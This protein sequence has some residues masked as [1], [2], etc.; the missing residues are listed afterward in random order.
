M[1]FNVNV[2]V[3]VAKVF[4]ALDVAALWSIV[5]VVTGVVTES[6]WQDEIK[7]IVSAERAKNDQILVWRIKFVN[8]IK[9]S[10]N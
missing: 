6:F 3:V 7:V 10:L 5:S 8:F 1:V 2:E 9:I 4:K